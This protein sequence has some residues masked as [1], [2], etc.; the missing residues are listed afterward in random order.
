MNLFLTFAF[1]FFFRKGR[2]SSWNKG[3]QTFGPCF[4]GRDFQ[5]DVFF[6]WVLDT[7]SLKLVSVLPNPKIYTLHLQNESTCQNGFQARIFHSALQDTLPSLVVFSCTEN[8]PY[9]TWVSINTS[10]RLQS[11]GSIGLEAIDGDNRRASG[12][13]R[14]FW[15]CETYGGRGKIGCLELSRRFEE[16]WSK[17]F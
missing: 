1:C 17:T 7:S 4:F 9:S 16:I 13:A 2:Q 10:H 12:A 15:P 11:Y 5:S 8:I 3:M 14:G 6:F